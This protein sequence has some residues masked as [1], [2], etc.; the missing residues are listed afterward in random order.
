LRVVP[1]DQRNHQQAE[2][3]TVSMSWKV[4]LGRCWAS[5]WSRVNRCS[6][7]WAW[8]LESIQRRTGCLNLFG[9]GKR[10][11]VP[12]FGPCRKQENVI[13][14]VAEK[15]DGP[16]GLDWREAGVYSQASGCQK[17]NSGPLHREAITGIFK[18]T[19]QSKWGVR[20]RSLLSWTALGV[21][22]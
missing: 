22:A 16:A 9:N 17:A 10:P 5:G 15:D 19:G 13:L 18:P 11:S 6:L 2:K 3:A 7:E 1:M 21:A 4:L 12:E 14:S 8:C 20:I